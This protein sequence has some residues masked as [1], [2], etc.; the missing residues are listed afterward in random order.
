MNKK[1]IRL[2]AIL[3]LDN[4]H[5]ITSEAYEHLA[6]M[7]HETGNQDIL[8]RVEANNGFYYLGENDAAELREPCP[9]CN[10]NS[11]K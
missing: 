11:C 5:G 3:I 4:E 7:L 9:D 2:L 6:T 10:G 1:T 8:N